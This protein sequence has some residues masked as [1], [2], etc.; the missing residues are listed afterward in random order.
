MR[1]RESNVS[2]QSHAAV[3]AR[4]DRRPPVQLDVNYEERRSTRDLGSLYAALEHQAIAAIAHGYWQE[5]GCPEG[6]AVE[7]WL[8]AEQNF[9]HRT[10]FGYSPDDYQVGPVLG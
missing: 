4:P 10:K 8:R 2:L 7:D 3:K 9:G 5:R 1:S 6:S